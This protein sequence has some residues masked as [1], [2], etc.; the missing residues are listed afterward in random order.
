MGSVALSVNQPNPFSRETAFTLDLPQ[1]G[2]VTLTIY[3]LRGRA[4]RT[5]HRAPLAAGPHEFHWDGSTSDGSPA[6]N[7]VYFYQATMAGHSVSRKLIL[8]RGN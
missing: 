5:L 1:S 2:D 6:P 3:D 4:I 8:M 7:G